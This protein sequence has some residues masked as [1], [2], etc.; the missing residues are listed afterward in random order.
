[1]ERIKSV[2]A[3]MGWERQSIKLLERTKE[4]AKFEFV[5]E[6]G[7]KVL[8]ESNGEAHTLSKEGEFLVLAGDKFSFE[9]EDISAPMS[10]ETLLEDELVQE[11]TWLLSEGYDFKAIEA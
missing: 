7:E 9:R 2:Y 6:D 4:G 3:M 1:M 8:N 10:T 5:T 11:M